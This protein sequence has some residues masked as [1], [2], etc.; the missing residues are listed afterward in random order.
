MST[1]TERN[2]IKFAFK[3]LLKAVG[4]SSILVLRW[5]NRLNI[6][7][8]TINFIRTLE[9]FSNTAHVVRGR[10]LTTLFLNVI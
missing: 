8:A 7:I 2:A 10:V 3:A 9:M 4:A 5:S 1:S 6:Q